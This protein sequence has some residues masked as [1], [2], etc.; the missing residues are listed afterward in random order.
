MTSIRENLPGRPPVA[1]WLHG[2]SAWEPPETHVAW[3]EEVGLLDEKVLAHVDPSE[4]LEEFPLKP[5]EILR[6]RSDRVLKHLKVLSRRHPQAHVWVISEGGAVEVTTLEKVVELGEG[7][8]A[9]RQVIL[10]PS[11]GG[12]K[13]GNAWSSTPRDT[14][15][16]TVAVIRICMDSCSSSGE[17]H[18]S[19]PRRRE[20]PT[21]RVRSDGTGSLAGKKPRG[22]PVGAGGDLD[23][24]PVQVDAWREPGGPVSGAPPLLL[25][26]PLSR[27]L[28]R[29]DPG[30]SGAPGCQRAVSLVSSCG[31]G[32]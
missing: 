9:W 30:R 17:R 16:S 2:I 8:L 29:A 26:R 31:G 28:R 14:P 5:H 22:F 1:D 18:R 10:P 11:V 6:D 24:V 7:G 13:E 23:G 20:D 3:R 15:R 32:A 4:L 19:A 27:G 25:A 21:C 12:L